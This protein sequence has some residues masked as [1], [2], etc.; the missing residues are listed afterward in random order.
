MSVNRIVGAESPTVLLPRNSNGAMRASETGKDDEVPRNGNRNHAEMPK[1][2]PK[3]ANESSTFR[4][5]AT[6]MKAQEGDLIA[7]AGVRLKGS[8]SACNTLTVEG[9]V[10]STVQARHLVILNGGAFVGKANVEEADIAGRFEGTLQ[11][12][13]KLIVRRSGRVI[14]QIAYGQIEVE[15]GGEL[16]GNIS[17]QVGNR[18]NGIFSMPG[19]GRL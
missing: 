11:T 18:K 6:T 17:L 2:E 19:Q 1:P 10:E 12:T 8:I 14:G 3:P 7:C 5:S 4:R 9:E 13:G 15:P 16:R